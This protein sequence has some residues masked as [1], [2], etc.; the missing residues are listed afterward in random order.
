[1]ECG[2]VMTVTL[3]DT[4]GKRCL[5]ELECLLEIAAGAIRDGEVVQSRDA[6]ARVTQR[7]GELEA[8]PLVVAG[9]FNVPAAGGQDAQDIVALR[10]R[11]GIAVR[12]GQLECLLRE[13]LRP[14]GST[15]AVG[16]QAPICVQSGTFAR[17]RVALEAMR[18]R[19]EVAL[20]EV[21]LAAA[22]VDIAEFVLEP[23]YL[24]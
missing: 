3:H 17:Q 6:C 12:L 23:R 11:P 2:L 14:R 19:L 22:A 20:G 16:D 15:T 18:S 1:M 5:R 8:L 24:G 9:M 10:P 4:Q 7:L 13:F 21:P